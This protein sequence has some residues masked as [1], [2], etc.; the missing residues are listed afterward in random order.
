MP[1]VRD[2]INQIKKSINSV[3][4]DVRFS[5]KFIYDKLLDI[6]KLLIRR[7]VEMRKIYSSQLFIP[8]K[9]IELETVDVASCTNITI[10]KC[11]VLSRSKYKI[12]KVFQSPNGSIIK[13]F[14]VE[15]SFE[16]HKTN[17]SDYVLISKREFKGPQKYYWIENDYLYIPGYISEVLVKGIFVDGSSVELLNNKNI[18]CSNFLNADSFIP[19]WL[20]KDAF[21]NVINNIA[22]VT[23]RIPEDENTNSNSNQ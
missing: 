9:C 10:P 3:N 12:P 20:R 2:D 4:P 5:N 18:K 22:S 14:S 7:E 8:I 19:D 1:S 15:E 16:F 17:I 13:V 21:D 23:K 6:T 11:N